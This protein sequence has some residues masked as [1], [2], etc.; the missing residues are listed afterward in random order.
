MTLLRSLSLPLLLAAALPAGA[1]RLSLEVEI[2]ALQ[3]AEYH[4]P[5]VALWIEREDASVAANLAVWYQQDKPGN[6]GDSG[7]K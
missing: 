1:A 5:Y 7:T 6:K 3:V 2:P 4:R